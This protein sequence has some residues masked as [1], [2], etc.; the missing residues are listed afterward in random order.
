MFCETSMNIEKKN[1]CVIRTVYASCSF[2]FRNLETPGFRKTSEKVQPY[3]RM[4]RHFIF[5]FRD[6]VYKKQQRDIGGKRARKQ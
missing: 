6:V 4:K 5:S 3:N 1:S 2:R